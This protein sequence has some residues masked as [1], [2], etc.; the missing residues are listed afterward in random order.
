M[1]SRFT[2]KAQEALNHATEAATVLGHSY[3]GSE[4]ILIGLIQTED[5]LA[6]AVLQSFDVTDEKIIN[7]VYCHLTCRSRRIQRAIWLYATI[8]KDS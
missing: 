8:E 3:I 6:S 2:K 1:Q 7:L 4:H 5:C